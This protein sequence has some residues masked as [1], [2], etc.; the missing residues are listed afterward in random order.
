VN[1]ALMFN[2]EPAVNS[3]ATMYTMFIDNTQREEA[4]SHSTMRKL[5]KG[6]NRLLIGNIQK[7]PSV[8]APVWTR[9]L[10]YHA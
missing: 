9:F 1:V 2:I 6:F 3:L 8:I 4:I 5:D 7:D 10:M